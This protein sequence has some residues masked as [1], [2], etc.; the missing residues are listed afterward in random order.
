MRADGQLRGLAAATWY[1]TILWYI[2]RYHR[3]LASLTDSSAEFRIM[4]N[5]HTGTN[6][7]YLKDRRDGLKDAE[8]MPGTALEALMYELTVMVAR[9]VGYDGVNNESIYAEGS[10][11]LSWFNRATKEKHLDD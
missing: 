2:I 8:P 4:Q 5:F 9:I 7:Q 1:A 6:P 10:K 3:T 11:L